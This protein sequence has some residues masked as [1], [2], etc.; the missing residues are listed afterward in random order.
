MSELWSCNTN[1]GTNTYV[2]GLPVSKD[3]G[4]IWAHLKAGEA[5]TGGDKLLSQSA[6]PRK[7][8]W[9]VQGNRRQEEEHE[10]PDMLATSK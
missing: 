10:A 9:H 7:N 2:P 4:T 5:G 6:V 3:S 1:S 8:F